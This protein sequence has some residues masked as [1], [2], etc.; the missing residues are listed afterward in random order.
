MLGDAEVHD[1]GVAVGGQHHVG[2]LQIA[3]NNAALAGEFERFG[4]L[5]GNSQGV[6][7]RQRSAGEA[8]FER[9]ALDELHG[10]KANSGSACRRRALADFVDLRNERMIEPRRSVGFSQQ[11]PSCRLVGS[12]ALR[13]ELERDLAIE[14]KILRQIHFAHTALAD[15]RENAVV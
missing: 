6:S 5:R 1:F 2:R 10:D 14:L 8:G 7:H 15:F 9:L 13:Q 11:T 4:N 12:L 3:M